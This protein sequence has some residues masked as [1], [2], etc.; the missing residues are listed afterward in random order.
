MILGVLCKEIEN[1]NVGNRQDYYYVYLQWLGNLKH[2]KSS[3]NANKTDF[4]KVADPNKHVKLN[5]ILYAMIFNDILYA[6][7]KNIVFKDPILNSSNNIKYTVMVIMKK[8][9]WTILRKEEQ[10]TKNV[11][12]SG[13]VCEAITCSLIT[14]QNIE[15]MLIFKETDL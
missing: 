4:S 6:S 13:F 2:P 10:L 15:I 9:I 7:N 11:F 14:S 1:I 5:D 8:W 3:D 12:K